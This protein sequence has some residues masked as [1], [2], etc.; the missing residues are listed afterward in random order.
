MYLGAQ[1]E[2]VST[3]DGTTCWTMSSVKYLK[4]AIANVE[5]KLGPNE[6]LPTRCDTPFSSGYHPAEDTTPELDANGLQYFQEMIGV[7][8][9]AVEIGRVDILLEVALLSTHLALPREGHMQQVLHIFAYLKKSPR[10]R[11]FFDPDHPTI[12]E[13]RF[14]SF[15]WEDFY[16]GVQEEI[17]PNMP[18]PRGKHVSTHCFVDAN[19]AADKVTRRSQTGIL[20]FINKAPVMWHSKRQNGVEASTFGSEFIALKNAIEL[21]VGIRYKLRM[22]GVPMEGATNIFCDNEAVY[23]NSST[24]ESTLNKKQHSIAYH[25][26]RSNVAMGVCRL[27]KEDTKTNLADLFTKCLAAI[28]RCELLDYFMY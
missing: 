11:L 20:I 12:S 18:E 28:K 4:A 22:F 23:K 2:E 26:C 24:P 1:I 15:D 14:K 25:Y 10:R 7:L 13:D 5:A 17:P 9:W 3:H 16:K 27:A 8:R 21:I 19:H 6:K